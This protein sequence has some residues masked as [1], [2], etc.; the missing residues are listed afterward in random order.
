MGGESFSVKDDEVTIW[1]LMPT[2]WNEKK[3]YIN[4][5]DSLKCIDYSKNIPT[6]WH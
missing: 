4:T 5:L 3:I 2:C 1:K 6:E